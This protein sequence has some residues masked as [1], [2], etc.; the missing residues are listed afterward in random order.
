MNK[1]TIAIVGA[2]PAGLMAAERIALQCP[3]SATDIYV[4]DAMPSVARKFLLAGIG[5]MNITHAE[6]YPDFVSRYRESQSWLTPILDEHTPEQLRAWIHDL[7]IDTFVGSSN[8]VFPSDMKAA[9]L[10]RRWKQRLINQGVRFFPRHRWQGW[11]NTQQLVFDHQG[12]VVT[13]KADAVVLALGG[14]SWAKLG[15][16]G[17]WVN[18]LRAQ[19]VEIKDLQPS[20]CG[21]SVPWSDFIRSNYGGTPLKNVTLSLTDN[22]RQH[23]RKIG[24]FV[25]TEYGIEG[26]LVYAFS[27]PLRDIL[28]SG[29]HGPQLQLDWLPNMNG[30]ALLSRLQAPRKGMSFS[31]LL[32]KKLKLPAITNALLRDCLPELNRDDPVAVCRALKNMPITVT[33]M[34]P[35]DEAISTAGG[36]TRQAVD[37][38]LM[39]QAHP[40]VFVAGEMLDWE[41]PTGGYLLT[42]CFATGKR[43]GDGVVKYLQER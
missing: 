26:S 33:G 1:A 5:G 25:I 40:S 27:A 8:R 11:N 30:E 4:Y 16:D 41:A 2:G 35:I 17:R 37:E 42:A 34:R 39:L 12:E 23:W 9:P 3:A 24:E 28:L 29:R 43:A 31:N 22:Q 32:R 13:V 20:N 18:T 15:S 7:G 19:G 36:V 6:P 38:N 21:F 10:L 14:G